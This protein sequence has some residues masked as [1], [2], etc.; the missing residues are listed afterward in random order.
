MTTATEPW[1]P[2]PDDSTSTYRSL[3]TVARMPTPPRAAATSDRETGEIFA[4]GT[5][6][7]GAPSQNARTAR[8]RLQRP[9]SRAALPHPNG[10]VENPAIGVMI[11]WGGLPPADSVP[12][13]PV[14]YGL[15]D[16]GSVEG[17]DPGRD[18]LAEDIIRRT[19]LGIRTGR[20]RCQMQNQHGRESVG[21]REIGCDIRNR[22]RGGKQDARFQDFETAAGRARPFRN[23]IA[24]TRTT[25]GFGFGAGSTST[26]LTLECH[27]TLRLFLEWAACSETTT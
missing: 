13:P 10:A 25:I 12:A 5:R 24:M 23:P 17:S 19:A 6:V 11:G 7:I 22:T 15:S 20:V 8:N 16:C 26:V 14:V 1:G 21:A 18:H 9:R 2:P 27:F 3:G 4:G